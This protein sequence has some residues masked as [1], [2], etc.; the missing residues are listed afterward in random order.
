MKSF[1]IALITLFVLVTPILAADDP[2]E[3]VCHGRNMT[4][5]KFGD[6]VLG[7]VFYYYFIVFI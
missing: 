3:T 1:N 5:G 4:N 7:E 2:Y 6:F